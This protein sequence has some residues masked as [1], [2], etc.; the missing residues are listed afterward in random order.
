MNS[1]AEWGFNSIPRLTIEK[2]SETDD[3]VAKGKVSNETGLGDDKTRES[4]E[5]KAK[6]IKKKASKG[7]TNINQ[8][9]SQSDT[10][11]FEFLM[12]PCTTLAADARHKPNIGGG[13][14]EVKSRRLYRNVA[15]NFRT[16][17]KSQQFL[18]DT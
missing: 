16:K 18:D 13:N 6:V 3:E 10:L 5:G 7:G 14:C 4:N 1:K 8:L 15:D 17:L 9:G 11:S 12:T 2:K